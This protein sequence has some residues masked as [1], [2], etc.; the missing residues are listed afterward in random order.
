MSENGKLRLGFISDGK[1]LVK[2]AFVQGQ[3]SEVVIG[4]SPSSQICLNNNVVSSQHA[5]LIFDANGNLHIIDLN[6]SNGTY[7]NN[8]RIEP[9]VPYQV[10]STDKLHFSGSA[11]VELVFNPD[12]YEMA[13]V[14]RSTSAKNTGDKNFST[15]NILEK[16]NG[17]RLL[18]VGRNPDCDVYLGHDSI[19]RNHATI[20]KKGPNEF[21]I[22]DLGSLNGTYVNGRRVNGNM[23]VSQN[24]TII[25]GRFQLSLSGKV[26][27]LTQEVA[28]RTERIIK[29]FDNGKI[30]LHECS[31]EIPSK[32]LL[33]VMGPSGCGKSTLLK[34]LN[35]DAPPSSGRVYISGLELNENYD[36]LKTQIGYVPQDDIVHR[37]LTVEQSLYYAAKLRLEHSDSTFIKQKIEQVLKD[38]N[39]E[40]IRFNLVGKIS[41]G[42]RKRVSIAVE[43]LTDPLILFLDE[44]TSPLDPQTIEEFLEI[45]RNLSNKGTTVI[46]VTHKPEDLNYM[47]TVIF[48]A[49]GGH[50]VYQG[51]TSSYL[52]HFKVEDT[53]K[54]YAQL[55]MPQ[56]TKWINNHKQN[57]PAL[58][59]MQPPKEKQ[60]SRHANFFHQ[61]WWLTIRYFNIKLNDRVNTLVLVGQA[62]IIAGL[63]CLIFQSISP[64]VP[65]LL[66]V[67]AVWFG[68]NNAAREI[69]GE[70]PIYKRERMFN[71]GILAYMLSKITVLG[72][73][74][75]IQ[76]LLFTL[77]ITINFSNSDPSWDAP[78]KTF[79][80]MLFVSLAASMMGLLLS[81]IVTTTEKVMTLVP[82]ALIPQIMLAGV[83]AKISS[84]LVEVLSYLTLSRWGNEGFCNVQENVRIEV[85]D[86]QMPPPQDPSFPSATSDVQSNISTKWETHSSIEQLKDCF[87]DNYEKTF[88]DDWAY[89]FNLDLIAVGSLSLLFFVGIYIALK[90]KDSIRIR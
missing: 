39:I 36:Y 12:S 88:G 73:F 87:H 29:Q 6:S 11:G 41:G 48:M 68:T 8:R 52:H 61:F 65:F 30:G 84:P 47:D 26:K 13:K 58:G 83:V 62:P 7:I 81:A 90:R 60:N 57:H 31:F 85:P 82:I 19:S 2:F 79:L 80:W 42:Q 38:L 54:V 75:A 1:L 45:L 24:D 14:Q 4:R 16:F 3:P 70:A 34:A 56:A 77:I 63:I 53:I 59:T 21:I 23:R 66:A 76:S 5:Q 35:G 15:T 72:T 86:I 50:K 22:T 40:H 17:K 46:M 78:A 74:A 10:R 18:T 51:D 9:G 89:S 69:V 44:P 71:Q 67:S 43:I 28:I 32:T 55:A 37:E 25:I 20:E 27:D 64:A 33:A 49:E